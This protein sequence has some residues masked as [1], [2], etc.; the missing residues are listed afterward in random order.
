LDVSAWSN[1]PAFADIDGDSDL[2][3]FVTSVG[4]GP[5]MLFVNQGDGTFIEQASARGVDVGR[6]SGCSE[7]T[8]ASFGDY[9]HD[10]DLDLYVSHWT[11]KLDD[12]N[13]LF[14]NDGTGH[15]TNVTQAA[16]VVL[17]SPFGFSSAFMDADG[18]GW[19]DLFVASDFETSRLFHNNHD[20]TFSD[21][22]TQAGVGTD[23]NGM[24][25][26]LGDV[27]G[28][29]WPDWFIT[30]IYQPGN[31]LYV[32]NGDGTF[33][34]RTNVYGV[35][36]SGWGWGALLFD[37]NNDGQLDASTTAGFSMYR[38]PQPSKLW[39]GGATPWREVAY[40]A[41]FA[42]MREGRAIVPIDFDRD[43]DLDT[44]TAN[45]ADLPALHRNDLELNHH[46]LVIKATGTSSNAHSIGAHV[47]VEH[48]DGKVQHRWITAN[49]T[50]QGHGPFEAHFG[51]GEDPGPYEVRVTW[52]VSGKSTSATSVTPD[53]IL[54]IEEPCTVCPPLSDAGLA[55]A[56]LADAGLADAGLDA[57]T[58][59]GP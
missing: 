16:G 57:A 6:P 33:V 4:P 18:D 45:V 20:G 38:P 29:G 35:A 12:L 27:N 55:D 28:D 30:A 47:E 25:S 43:G 19:E 37:V 15:F 34:D 2:D 24:G 54:N 31:K 8:S 13:Y 49:S 7:V 9:D 26:A 50:L 58:D 48:P 14:Q 21:V 17:P 5:S 36:D 42:D 52:P 41:G 56:G 1:G 59:A 53:Q 3:L 23:K 11:R 10:H 40:Q 44:F 51:L 39:L 46:W 32:N 22:T